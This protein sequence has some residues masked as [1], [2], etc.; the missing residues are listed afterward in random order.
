M[1][2][3]INSMTI[4][5]LQEQQKQIEIALAEKQKEQDAKIA[6]AVKE[7]YGSVTNI[8][9]F[10]EDMNRYISI[11]IAVE[12][13]F[14]STDLDYLLKQIETSVKGFQNMKANPKYQNDP[15]F[16]THQ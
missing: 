6:K 7:T 11:S 16:Q 4:E 12:N 14:E 15:N 5:E 8:K 10:K 1:A 13:G 3:N 2:K 9:K